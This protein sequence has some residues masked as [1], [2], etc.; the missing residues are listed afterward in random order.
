L[1]SEEQKIDASEKTYEKNLQVK[2]LGVVKQDIARDLK[3]S[4][5][6]ASGAVRCASEQFQQCHCK[7]GNVIY[8]GDKFSNNGSSQV[9]TYKEMLQKPHISAEVNAGSDGFECT[10][11]QSTAQHKKQCFCVA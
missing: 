2:S 8:F 10:Q 11:Y 4:E 1:K 5:K 6:H 7:P 9:L 3:T